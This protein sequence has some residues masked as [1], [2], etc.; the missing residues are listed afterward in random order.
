MIANQSSNS[1]P[2]SAY[3]GGRVKYIVR[4]FFNINSQD[5]SAGYSSTLDIV[6]VERV[7]GGL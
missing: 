2:M 6:G 7:V 4:R 3:V 1:E 5:I